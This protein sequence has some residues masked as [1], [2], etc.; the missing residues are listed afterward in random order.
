MEKRSLGDE[1]ILV[2]NESIEELNSEY[3]SSQMLTSSVAIFRH[4]RCLEEQMPTKEKI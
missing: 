3:H 4:S 2:E 1:V